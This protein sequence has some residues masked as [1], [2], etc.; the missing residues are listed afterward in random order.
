MSLTRLIKSAF[1]Q[2]GLEIHRA[3]P[4]TSTDATPVTATIGGFPILV[5]GDTHL[6]SWFAGHPD[7]LRQL[8]RL[9][10]M[11]QAE[12]PDLV[13]VDVGANV[14][15][16]LALIKAGADVPVICVE[17]DPKVL[18]LTRRNVAQFSRIQLVETYVAE[19]DSERQVAI[20]KAGWNSTLSQGSG[21]QETVRFRSLDN[22]LVSLGGY[23]RH[24]LLKV[25]VEGYEPQVLAG[26]GGFLAATQPVVV[27]EYNED[28]LAE[29]GQDGDGLLGR[30]VA[31][32]YG[33][34]LWYEAE[35]AYLTAGDLSDPVTRAE[36]GRYCRCRY[37]T[38][39][40]L[41]LIVFPVA[42]RGLFERFRAAE[43]AHEPRSNRASRNVRSGN[44]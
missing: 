42:Q 36:I 22:I 9:S 33:P 20:S 5:P 18:P 2:V 17:G 40:Y 21:P 43:A 25:D 3:A 4:P 1:R 35:G 31:A 19:R 41:D 26:A 28:A 10:R 13:A 24:G 7:Y 23:P 11:L 16:S 8:E 27:V 29:T 39:L 15:D 14:G 37:R 34:V 38:S 6:R 32:G 12:W 30:L 44:A